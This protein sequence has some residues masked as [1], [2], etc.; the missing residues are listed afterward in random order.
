MAVTGT[1]RRSCM[2]GR[3]GDAWEGGHVGRRARRRIADRTVFRVPY[4]VLLVLYMPYA[5]GVVEGC[6]WFAGWLW[7]ACGSSRFELDGVAAGA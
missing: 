3:G 4:A 6:L 1:G 2:V 5:G 7:G